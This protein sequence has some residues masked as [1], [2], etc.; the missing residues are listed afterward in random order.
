LAFR[1]DPSQVDHW[2]DHYGFSLA[3]TRAGSRFDTYLRE[4]G[5]WSVLGE[6]ETATLFRR[7]VRDKEFPDK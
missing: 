2:A 7:D 3:L 5:G 6:T 1:D 4:G